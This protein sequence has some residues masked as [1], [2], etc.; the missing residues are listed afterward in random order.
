M[1][2]LHVLL[3]L[4]FI[5]VTSTMQA[6][7]SLASG[8][9]SSFL[10]ERIQNPQFQQMSPEERAKQET[11]WMKTDLALTAQ[12]LS[13]VDSINLKYAKMRSQLQGQDREARMAKMQELQSQKEGELKSVLTE[14]QM[15]KYKELLPQRRGM[16]N[17]GQ[18]RG[19]Q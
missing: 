18:G 5:A 16:R 14:D 7:Q 1:R 13:K 19:N 8:N 10:P 2:S 9:L 6:G 11:Q 17:Q 3:G 12:Q 4:A 15:K